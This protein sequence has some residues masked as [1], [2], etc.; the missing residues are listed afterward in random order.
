M[1]TTK[2]YN[3]GPKQGFQ[4][5]TVMKF[6]DEQAKARGLTEKDLSTM[7]TTADSLAQRDRYD[8]AMTSQDRM[9]ERESTLAA[10]QAE[11]PP[12]KSKKRGAPAAAD[13]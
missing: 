9:R 7:T 13:S 10:E 4:Q 3:V 8:E 1:A 11:E 2:R 6:T 5:K 12:A